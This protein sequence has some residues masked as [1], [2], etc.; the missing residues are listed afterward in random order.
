M[1]SGSDED[2][3]NSIPTMGPGLSSG[4]IN[5]TAMVTSCSSSRD[6]SD[7]DED[8]SNKTDGGFFHSTTASSGKIDATAMATPC[9]SSRDESSEGGFSDSMIAAMATLSSTSPH[10]SQGFFSTRS[11]MGSSSSSISVNNNDVT[12][13]LLDL[14]IWKVWR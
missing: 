11:T 3:F 14:G 5:T 6:E 1:G 13:D 12:D 9:S 10:E 8:S 2:P 4:E 7:K